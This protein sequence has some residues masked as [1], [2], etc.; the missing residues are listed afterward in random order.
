MITHRRRKNKYETDKYGGLDGKQKRWQIKVQKD[1]ER[2]SFYSSKPGRT[3]QREANAKADAWLDDNIQHTGKRVSD[4]YEQY[5]AE[6]KLT[7]SKSNWRSLDSYGR[8]WI[9]PAIGH[10]KISTVTD[11]DYQQIINKMFADG[12]AKKTLM[13]LRGTI[14]EFAKFCRR[15][16]VSTLNPEFLTIPNGAPVKEKVILQ[17]EDIKTLFTSDRTMY[18]GTETIEPLVNAFRFQLLTGLRPGELLGLRWD[19][20]WDDTVHIRRSIN[21]YGEETKGKNKNAARSFG[22]IGPAKQ[23]LQ[24]QWKNTNPSAPTIFP[25][26]SEHRYRIRLLNYCRHNH[27]PEVSPYELRHTFVSIVK[28]LP[29]GMI[30]SLV[31]HSADMDTLGIYSHELSDDAMQTANEVEKVFNLILESGL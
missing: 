31:G 15:L 8:N 30:K 16:R 18:N 4:L 21:F 6:K 14:T 13:N 29:E 7:T 28:Q 2:R 11:N 17:K 9:L 22:L 25:K 5:I 1:G 20:I 24:E 3:G 23:I 26:I 27:L 19:D 12:K 10:R